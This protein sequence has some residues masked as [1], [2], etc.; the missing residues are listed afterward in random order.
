MAGTRPGWTSRCQSGSAAPCRISSASRFAARSWLATSAALRARDRGCHR[1]SSPASSAPPLLT[2]LGD[3][4]GNPRG[5]PP[6]RGKEGVAVWD[7]KVSKATLSLDSVHRHYSLWY[8]LQ[9]RI[10]VDSAP[11]SPER[12]GLKKCEEVGGADA[13]CG[14]ECIIQRA[15]DNTTHRLRTN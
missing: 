9:G 3:E 8:I 13:G 7:G 14:D 11:G 6:L 15:R 10:V 5:R 4:C 1:D 2:L 12:G